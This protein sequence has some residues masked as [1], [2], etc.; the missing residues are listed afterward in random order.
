MSRSFGIFWSEWSSLN[1]GSVRSCWTMC[2]WYFL[3]LPTRFPGKTDETQVCQVQACLLE[4]LLFQLYPSLQEGTSDRSN[5]FACWLPIAMAI[6]W[7]CYKKPQDCRRQ[8]G[9]PHTQV[10]ITSTLS[11]AVWGLSVI[12]STTSL[13]AY[14][15][16]HHWCWMLWTRVPSIRETMWGKR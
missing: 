4:T 10:S 12:C 11:P 2:T 8:K 15:L 16:S 14:C 13:P 3:V 1:T 6:W 5:I 9:T 7:G